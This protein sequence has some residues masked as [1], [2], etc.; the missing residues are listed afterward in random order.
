MSAAA[1]LAA[2]EGHLDIALRHLETAHAL[3]GQ[4]QQLADLAGVER[5]AINGITAEAGVVIERIARIVAGEDLEQELARL[6][7]SPDQIDWEAGA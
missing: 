6:S 7:D 5:F 3:V 4:D 1:D 2:A